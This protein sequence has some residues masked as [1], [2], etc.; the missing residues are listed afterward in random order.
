MS[1]PNGPRARRFMHRWT[2]LTE[3]IYTYG[4]MK[5]EN[6]P[7]PRVLHT[8]HEHF[9]AGYYEMPD[10]APL[11]RWS[12]ALRR[13]FEHYRLPAYR[14]EILYPC[15]ASG[16][17]RGD[18]G[19]ILRPSYSFTWRLDGAA[20]ERFRAA[21]GVGREAARASEQKKELERMVEDISELRERI[22]VWRSPHTVGGYSYT[23]SIP[24]YGRVLREGLEG[25]A[26]RISRQGTQGVLADS[27]L[28]LLEGIE[29][30]RRSIVAAVASYRPATEETARNRNRLLGAYAR[31]PRRPARTFFEALAAYNFVYYMDGCDNPGRIDR[32]LLPFYLR[33]RN[34]AG[35]ETGEA[36]G[37][38]EAFYDNVCA[39]SGWSA[40]L[41]G[42]SASLSSSASF[43]FPSAYTELTRLCILAARNRF[44]P[45]LE[46]GVR[47]DM[48][49]D[50]WD[51]ALETLATGGG[52]PAFYNDQAYVDG[53]IRELGVAPDDAVRWNG[54]GCTETMVHG[55]SNVGSL[56]AGLN[57]GLVLSDAIAEVLP[58][59]RSYDVFEHGLMERVSAAVAD[60]TVGVGRM[61]ENK[62]ALCPQP[63]RTLLVD[64]CIDNGLEFN[65][66]GARYNWSVIN[67][68]GLTN[69][70]DSLAAVKETVFDRREVSGADLFAAI[71]DDFRGSEPLRRRLLACPKF[72]NDDDRVD[73]IAARI[74]DAVFDEFEKHTPW[75]GGKFL[76]SCIMFTTYAKA[77]EAV[78]ATPDGRHSGEP[79]ADSI[80]AATGRDSSGPTALVRSVTRRPLV[81]ALGTPVFNIRFPKTLLEEPD[82]RGGVRNLIRS[83]FALGGMQVQCTVVD[84]A[85]LED[86]LEHPERHGDL[87]VR[88]GGYSAYFNSLSRELKEAVIAR[89]EHVT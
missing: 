45:S 10:V 87:I 58:E 88:I 6:G 50:I 42:S 17:M 65:A 44:R 4:T 14:G 29:D 66:G 78:G 54:G 73:E 2:G 25:Y 27:M 46:L 24:H 57:L 8:I 31:V 12:R 72:G 19:S 81:R 86:A 30:W 69:V 47:D 37:L 9:A 33:D 3:M 32:E 7:D 84:R 35:L 80:G 79:L 71:R 52:Q 56:D 15:G 89:T 82:G 39:M 18:A 11:R 51:A 70:A 53:L 36:L 1:S 28:D 16:P 21:H 23:H 5:T 34:D 83:Y 67:I 64:D 43:S 75:R 41:G 49:E 76:P 38:L 40:A 85:E 48:P 26:S 55:C 59:A 74:D 13:Q 22:Y 60:L 63:M 62:A 20:I 68:A 61:Q 77:G